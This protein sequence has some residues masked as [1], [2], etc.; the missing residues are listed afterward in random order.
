VP[1][2][3]LVICLLLSKIDEKQSL[4]CACSMLL[5]AGILQFILSVKLK[6][7]AKGGG[8]SKKND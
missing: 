1:L 7:V 5:L 3:V 2:N 8:D 4:T 6:S